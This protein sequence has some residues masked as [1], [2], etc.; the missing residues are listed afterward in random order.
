MR[1]EYNGRME[2]FSGWNKESNESQESSMMSK[3]REWLL[4]GGESIA[5]GVVEATIAWFVLNK[6]G[7]DP[8]TVNDYAPVLAAAGASTWFAMRSTK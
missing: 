1:P 8:Q 7:I 4:R 5:V 2:R 3:H 6:L